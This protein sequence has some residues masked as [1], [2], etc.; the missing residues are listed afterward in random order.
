MNK[1][2]L[3]EAVAEKSGLSKKAAGD[4]I[5]AVLSTIEE[6]LAKGESV[7]LVGFGT[8]SVVDRAAREGRN[9]S[10]GEP[11]HIAASKAVKFSAGKGFKDAV[12]DT[13]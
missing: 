5:S 12:N 3:I 10:T 7:V 9:P 6:Q 2:E 13:K 11:L 4:A 8:F 1:N